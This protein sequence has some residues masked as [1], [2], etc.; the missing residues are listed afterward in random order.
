MFLVE[1]IILKMDIQ[2]ETWQKTKKKA[3]ESLGIKKDSILGISQGGM[4]AQYLAID[5]PQIVD[6]LIIGVS[7]SKPNDNM[8]KVIKDWII[9][10]KKS[11]YKN[12]VIDT[13][14][15]TFTEHKVKK[16]RTL[17]PIITRVGKPKDFNR[18]II[19]ANSCLNHNAYDEL[20]KI[21]SPTLVIGGKRDNIV[22]ENASE[23]MAER[24]NGSKLILYK[25][26]GHGAYEE[27]KDFNQQVL[28]F[29]ISE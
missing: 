8:Q 6:K 20:D 12:L 3:M 11:D 25:G 10:A 18:F 13:I 24:I 4:I 16:Y 2:P 1:R 29:L 23:D 7:V 26:L 19:Q 14:E 15:K 17:Y 28:N 5:N 22:G 27:A 21:K 9:L